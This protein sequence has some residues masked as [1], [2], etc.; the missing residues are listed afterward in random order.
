[1]G[2]SGSGKT[3]VGVPLAARLGVDYGEAD[4]FH[5]QRNVDKMAAGQALDDEDRRPWLQ[6]IGRW[7]SERA[8]QGGVAT[9]SALARRY[10]DTLRSAAPATVFLHLEVDREV[11]EQR[12][13]TR[14]GHFMPAKLLASQLAALEPLEPDEPGLTVDADAPLDAVLEAFDR[15]WTTERPSAATAAAPPS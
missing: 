5:P 14:K 7:L 11:L 13:A 8:D 3:T 9:C 12:M 2:V 15:W 6:A 1:M 4:D 10:R